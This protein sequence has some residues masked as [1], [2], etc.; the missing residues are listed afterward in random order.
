MQLFNIL[1]E[2]EANAQKIYR[3]I[4]PSVKGTK[5]ELL[6][7]ACLCFKPGGRLMSKHLIPGRTYLEQSNGG[8]PF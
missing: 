4:F 1:N 3:K 8:N 2:A 6:H 5:M 7:A